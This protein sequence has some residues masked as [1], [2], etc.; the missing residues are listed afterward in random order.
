MRFCWSGFT[1]PLGCGHVACT[2]RYSAAL[3]ELRIGRARRGRKVRLP[4]ANPAR[5]IIGTS[6][7]NVTGGW[8]GGRPQRLPGMIRRR[9]SIAA[10]S[11]EGHG[12]N[13]DLYPTVPVI[14][15]LV[16]A[17]TMVDKA[18]RELTCTLD[19]ERGVG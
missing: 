5:G 16:G 9:S 12:L 14:P 15:G 13:P 3:A 10:C 1:T 8:L 18:E 19:G 11:A 7:H 6:L 17:A 4:G 2:D